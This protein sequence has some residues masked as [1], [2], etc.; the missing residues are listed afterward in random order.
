MGIKISQQ[1]I[2]LIL[3]ELHLGMEVKGLQNGLSHHF[4]VLLC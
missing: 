3:I 1:E 4:S 2:L